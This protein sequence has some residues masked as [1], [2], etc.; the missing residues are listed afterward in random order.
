MPVVADQHDAVAGRD[1]D[2]GH[3]PDERTE[4]QDAAGQNAATIAPTSANG[5]VRKTSAARRAEPKSTQ[6][7][8]KMAASAN[9]PRE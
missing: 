4:R 7:S 2:D 5:S 1:A 8:R 3:E 9:A 6:Q